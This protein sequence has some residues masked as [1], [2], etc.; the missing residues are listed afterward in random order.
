MQVAGW[1]LLTPGPKDWKR[2]VLAG[3]ARDKEAAI[4]Y[5][6]KR[7]PT[8]DMFPG[9]RRKAADGIADAVCIADWGLRQLQKRPIWDSHTPW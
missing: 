2:V 5:V 6:A 7:F 8:V 3:T 4:E 9:R 1:P